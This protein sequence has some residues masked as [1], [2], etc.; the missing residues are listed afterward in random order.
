MPQKFKLLFLAV[1]S[2]G[3]VIFIGLLV[4]HFLLPHQPVNLATNSQDNS[5]TYTDKKIIAPTV[6]TLDA[7]NT[8]AHPS[9]K[10]STV[11]TRKLGHFAYQEADNNKLMIIGSYAKGEYQRFEL[12]DIEAGKALM[13]L[14]SAARDEG[15]WIIPVSGFRTIEYQEKLFQAQIKRRG[16]EK[17]AA[18]LSA[19][20]GY[21]EHHTGLAIDLANGKNI[22]QDVKYEFAQSD[23]FRWMAL[24]G[25]EYGFEMSFPQGNT[26]GVSYEP[27]HWRYVGSPEALVTFK[28]TQSSP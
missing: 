28:N 1:I 20:P 26:Q 23:A 3:C 24:H 18:K 4:S 14:I 13:K 16:S 27:W 2:S 10:I 12:M 15:I 5:I 21:S 7:V 8:Q 19:P 9:H 6:Q 11:S 17:E 22:G 25:K